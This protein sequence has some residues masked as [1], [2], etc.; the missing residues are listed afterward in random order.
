MA[1]QLPSAA[2][3]NDRFAGHF[4]TSIFNERPLCAKKPD[5]SSP[6]VDRRSILVVAFV[7]Q[8]SRFV[9]AL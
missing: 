4:R 3:P 9:A 8:A 2:L 5:P 1:A 7:L 6:A